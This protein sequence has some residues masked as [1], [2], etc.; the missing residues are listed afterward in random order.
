MVKMLA[1]VGTKK[2]GK[3]RL[4]TRLVEVFIARG[5]RVGV[6]KSSHHKID[7]DTSGTDTWRFRE[8]GASRVMLVG[9]EGAALPHF[10]TDLNLKPQYLAELCM[11][12][13]DL[14]L[15]EGFKHSPLKKIYLSGEE[16]EPDFNRRG[17]IA[18]VGRGSPAENTPDFEPDDIEGLVTFIDRKLLKRKGG[19]KMDIEVRVDGKKIGLKGFVKDILTNAIVGMISALKG[20]HAPGKIE[21]LVDT[22]AGEEASETDE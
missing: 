14:V 9:P 5:V 1:I 4:I 7:L 15:L 19:T 12:D 11:N 17:L 22:A 10:S 20:C 2:S 8:S 21:I 13:L 16:D 18:T 3:T 6:I